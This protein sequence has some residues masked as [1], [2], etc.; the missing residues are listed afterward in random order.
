MLHENEGNI[1]FCAARMIVANWLCGKVN[2]RFLKCTSLYEREIVIFHAINQNNDNTL[3]TQDSPGAEQDPCKS[4]CL[5]QAAFY[6]ALRHGVQISRTQ[7]GKGAKKA[8]SIS[9][10]CKTQTRAAG[11]IAP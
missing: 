6:A 10:R 7:S 9:A 11:R 1:G 4:N 3:T 5:E 8:F 2:R